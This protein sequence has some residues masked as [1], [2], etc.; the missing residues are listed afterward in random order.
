[1]KDLPLT[2]TDLSAM[3]AIIRES[4][5]GIDIKDYL[6]ELYGKFP[7]AFVVSR[8]ANGEI[9]G[10]A[11]I[12]PVNSQY[13]ARFENGDFAGINFA[14]FPEDAIAPREIPYQQ[15]IL[16]GIFVAEK[17]RG[18]GTHKLMRKIAGLIHER[19]VNGLP[20]MRIIALADIPTGHQFYG[21]CLGMERVASFER[22]IA[23]YAATADEFVKGWF[24]RDLYS[25][26]VG[27]R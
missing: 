9:F 27:R 21:D 7:R 16:D 10:F 26:V 15:V 22:D 25:K 23:I 13:A 14:P 2:A 18:L 11:I 12:V 5:P 24:S 17:S 20:I 8:E 19:K 3:E 1:M 4:Y 6:K